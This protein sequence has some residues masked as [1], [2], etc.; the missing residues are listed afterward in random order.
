METVFF[1][2][3]YRKTWRVAQ[4]LSWV[5]VEL[6]MRRRVQMETFIL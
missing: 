1:M 6:I 4:L 2:I 3:L 5:N